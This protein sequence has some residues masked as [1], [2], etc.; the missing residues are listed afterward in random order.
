MIGIFDSG[1]GGLS[2]YRTI[3]DKLPGV[4]LLY[5][6][7][8]RFAPYGEKTEEE[9]RM[10][11]SH[12][13][14][15]LKNKGAKII[16]IACNTATVAAIDYLRESYPDLLFVGM[17]AP[18]KMALEY[19]ATAR[20]GVLA[21]EVMIQSLRFQRFLK[22]VSA[23]HPNAKIMVKGVP[24]LV[25]LVES[26]QFFNIE[27]E[28]VLQD[29]FSSLQEEFHFNSLVIGCTHLSFLGPLIQRVVGTY[30]PL[31][32][33]REETAHQTRRLYLALQNKKTQRKSHAF[34]TTGSQADLKKFLHATF[35]IE[36]EV[37]KV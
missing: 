12:I 14:R 26:H 28:I 29:F 34:F 22:E 16:V 18:V 32:D 27:S 6:S 37:Y 9:I 17:V 10:R 2:L 3:A 21:T 30:T 31:F 20:V 4:P 36:A 1:V 5:V 8:S 7:D 15:F 35:A 25:E 33:S 19:N 24:T 13:T 11:A 23:P